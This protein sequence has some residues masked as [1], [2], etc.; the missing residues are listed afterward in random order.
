MIKPSRDGL[1]VVNT[2]VHMPPNFSAFTSVDDVIATAVDEGVSA[3]GI[4]NFYDQTV[5]RHF[6]E[7]ATAAG[8]VALYGLE[9]ITRVDD[10]GR[11]GIRVNDPA[12]AGRF[13][14]C[15]KGIDMGRAMPATASAIR[16]GNDQRAAAMVAL[17][18][19]HLAAA[20]VEGADA[21]SV[22]VIAGAVARRAG[23][24]VEWVS[25]QERHIAMAVQEVLAKL[26][27]DER[28]AALERAYGRSSTVDIDDPVALQGEIRSRLLKAGTPAFVPEVPVGFDEAYAFVLAM[29]GMPVYPTLADGTMPMCEF[30]APAA[31]LAQKVLARGIHATELIPIRIKSVVVDEY[32]QAFL[33]AGLVVMAGTEHNT[34]ERIPIDPFCADGPMSGFAR[35]AF[36]EGTCVVAAHQHLVTRGLAGFV[37]AAGERTG[38]TVTE[39]ASLGARINRGEAGCDGPD[40]Q[41]G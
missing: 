30:E 20:G 36:W 22:E 26:P 34:A 12:N 1:P 33:D 24:P 3:L 18:S 29:G 17:V 32:V 19:A 37:D 35:R 31:D 27:H 14:L 41:D 8:I 10:L 23:V 5:Y 40:R 25:L 21:L 6:G 2:H 28:A 4:S 38:R 16:Q 39:L 13:Y 7:T 11:D 15:G 9:F